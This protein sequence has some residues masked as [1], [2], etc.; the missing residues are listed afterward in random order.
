MLVKAAK[1]G[2]KIMEVPIN[3]RKR[4]GAS[5]VSGTVKG[6]LLAAYYMLWIPLRYTIKE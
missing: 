3:Y 2:A 6:S 4:I 1:R 5:K